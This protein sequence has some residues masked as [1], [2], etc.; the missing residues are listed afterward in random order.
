MSPRLGRRM[1]HFNRRVT[2]HLTRPLAR[3]M[4]G[5]GIVIHTGRKS[6]RQYR[7]PVNV[8]GAHG[9]YVIA[10]TYGAESDWVKNVLA[11]GGCELI[12]RGRRHHLTSPQ[13]MHDKSQRPVPFVVRPVLRLLR[14]TDFMHLN[15]LARNRPV[16]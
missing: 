3:W 9:S 1:A 2:N 6:K 10:L 13:I 16:E 14:V 7:T 8:F 12:T 15:A 4:P 5:F 11:A